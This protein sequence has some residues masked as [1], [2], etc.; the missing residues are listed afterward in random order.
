VRFDLG[1]SAFRKRAKA[2]GWRRADQA[3]DEPF[4]DADDAADTG[5]DL[6][7]AKRTAPSLAGEENHLTALA[8]DGWVDDHFPTAAAKLA[9][10]AWAAPASVPTPGVGG[11]LGQGGDAHGG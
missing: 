7:L 4:A 11:A 1:L 2:E 6:L 9:R 8:Q 5:G 3:E 10:I